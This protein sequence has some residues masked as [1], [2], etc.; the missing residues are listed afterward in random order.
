MEFK[1]MSVE[2]LKPVSKGGT[3][4][5]FLLDDEKILKLYYKGFP[6]NRAIQ[7][8]KNAKTAFVA[9]VPT[10]ISFDLVVSDGRYGIIYEKLNE[11]TMSEV[12][13]EHPSKA[14]YMGKQ[15]ALIA[16]SIHTAKVKDKDFPK[17]TEKIAKSIPNATYLDDNT[18]KNVENFMRT[19]ESTDSYVHG[20]FHTNNVMIEGDDIYLIDMGSYSIGSPLFDL[21]VLHFSLFD[22]P[23]S[24]KG[25]ISSFNGLNRNTR[26]RFWN[27][28]IDEYYKNTSEEIK[29]E[30]ISKMRKVIL[31]IKL[32]FEALYGKNV[33]EE[34]CREVRKQVMKV[35]G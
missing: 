13:Q 22:S 11:K 10:P 5:C 17:S 7:E 15:M 24:C 8:K 35:F 31:L 6:K 16:Q 19:L 34:Y 27:A 25:D 30:Q 33:P 21:A 3:G 4:E 2:G 20:D 12:L 32:R 1:N 26:T 28:F 9:G 29:E 18:R 23:E 14:A